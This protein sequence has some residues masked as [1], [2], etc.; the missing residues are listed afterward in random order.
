MAEA[1]TAQVRKLAAIGY[2]EASIDNNPQEVRGIAFTVANRMRAWGAADVDSL[3]S[4]VGKGY[5]VAT[6]GNNVRYN[7]LMAASEVA[8]NADP[9][10][11]SAVTSAR[12]AL[13]NRG[14]DPSNGAYWWDGV[15]LKET[16][17]PRHSSGFHYG[18]A[19]HNIFGIT[20]VKLAERI[21]YWTQLNKKTNQLVNTRERGRYSYK[22]LSTAAIGRTIFWTADPDYIKATGAKDYK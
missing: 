5:V 19:S 7:K 18:S 10:M 22:Y 2:G 8:I 14:N 6:R 16:S 12:D 3:L 11:R 20:E 1:I 13:A 9:D 4:K 21:T 15:D 17:N